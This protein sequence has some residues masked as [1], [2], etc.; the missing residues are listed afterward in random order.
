MKF[1]IYLDQMIR[2]SRPKTK[3]TLEYL[4]STKQFI[5]YKIGG[6]L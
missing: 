5:Q 1:L 4:T 6:E 3:I 2:R